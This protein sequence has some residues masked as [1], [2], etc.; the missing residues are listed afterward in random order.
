MNAID[1]VDLA[2]RHGYRLALDESAELDRDQESRAW[3]RRIPAKYGFIAPH[4]STEPS[5]FCSA[6][7]LFARLEAIPGVR[8]HQVG[9]KEASF[10][11]PPDQL[12]AVA[13]VLKAK[14]KRRVS[15]AER[16][17][18]ASLSQ[19]HSPLRHRPERVIGSPCV[20]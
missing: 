10:I 14:R 18:L 2:S 15:D 6:R 12:D 11:F 16:A 20:S 9:D 17:R 8:P 1:L 13:E 19:R 5:A 4:S 3:Y 7:R